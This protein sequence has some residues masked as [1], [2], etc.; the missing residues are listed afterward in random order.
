MRNLA[1]ALDGRRFWPVRLNRIRRVRPIRQAQYRQLALDR[2]ELRL[3]LDRP[4]TAQE[5]EAT[6]TYVREALGHP[7]QVDIFPVRSVE[8][9]PTGKFEEFV[10]LVG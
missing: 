7:F 1:R 4:L 3:V 6:V 2:I 9:G 8:R 5:S 10:S